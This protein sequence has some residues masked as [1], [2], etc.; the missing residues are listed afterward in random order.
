MQTNRFEFVEGEAALAGGGLVAVVLVDHL[1]HLVLRNLE[2][3]Q[4]QR[5]FQLGQF[6]VARSVHIDLRSH[7]SNPSA[8]R[9]KSRSRKKNRVAR[10]F[11]F[12]I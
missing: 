11:S 5:L 3:A 1:A 6:D 8:V 12:S 9:Q 10:L 4:V 7:K 2:A